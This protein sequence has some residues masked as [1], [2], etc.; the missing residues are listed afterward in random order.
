MIV[1][2]MTTFQVL[3]AANA[4]LKEIRREF[5]LDLSVFTVTTYVTN[6]NANECSAERERETL[7]KRDPERGRPWL[8]FRLEKLK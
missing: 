4:N 7:R 3:K 2:I 1:I 6:C 8:E 5:A